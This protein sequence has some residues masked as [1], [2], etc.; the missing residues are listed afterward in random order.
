[1][2]I[3]SWLTAILAVTF[4]GAPFVADPFTG[5]ASDMLPIPQDNAPIIPAGYAFSIWGIIYLGL[6]IS[7]LYG[8][9][10][11]AEDPEWHRARL[12]LIPSLAIGTAWLFIAN[13]SVTW[14]TVTIWLMLVTALAALYLSPL[15]NRI[16]LRAPV[17]LYAG[18]LSAA[19]FVSLAVW[20]AGNFYLYE[21]LGWALILIPCATALATLVM[22]TTRRAPEYGVA[23]TWALI[24]IAVKNFGELS[25]PNVG[26]LAAG[27]AALMALLTL[28]AYRK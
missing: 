16:W 26:Y 5:F 2:K 3:A 15:Q 1:M 28:R 8:A 22:L 20:L 24:G 11:H 21:E 6:V 17:G 10:R 18:W 7:G 23:V 19:S 4:A 27:C 13:A 25:I 12:V 14:A 9:F